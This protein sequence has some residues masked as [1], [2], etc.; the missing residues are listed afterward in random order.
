[1]VRLGS[2]GCEGRRSLSRQEFPRSVKVVVIKRATRENVVYC[3]NCRLPAKKFQIDHI[4]ADAICGKP[5]IE[6]AMLI[7]DVCFG[8]KNPQDT[9]LAAKAKRREARHIGAKTT[10]A[11]AIKSRGF[12]QSEKSAKREP[13]LSLPPLALFKD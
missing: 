12:P 1:M 9:T 7:C 8:I 6:N 11:H 3:E 4:I 13:R 5:V 2:E 10:S